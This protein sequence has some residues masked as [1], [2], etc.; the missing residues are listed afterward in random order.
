MNSKSTSEIGIGAYLG[1]AVG[2]FD[3]AEKQYS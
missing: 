1:L 3:V 2:Y